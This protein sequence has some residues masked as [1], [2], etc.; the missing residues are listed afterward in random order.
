VS[1]RFWNIV[2]DLGLGSYKHKKC[3]P[4]DMETIMGTWKWGQK[5]LDKIAANNKAKHKGPSN[6][7]QRLNYDLAIVVQ[8][9]GDYKKHITSTKE[10]QAMVEERIEKQ[11][12]IN[13]ENLYKQ[14]ASQAHSDSIIDLMNE[15]F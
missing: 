14:S 7:E 12:K 10:E 11:S 3:N 2:S 4:I 9:V 8:H 5:H 6:D 13:Y 1:N 15:I